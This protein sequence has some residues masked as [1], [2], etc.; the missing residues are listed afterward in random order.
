LNELV[1]HRGYTTLHLACFK[2]LDIM[3]EYI[4]ER[5]KSTL[6]PRDLKLWIDFKTDDDGFTALHFASFRGSFVLLELLL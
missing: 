3:A 5:A 2:N 1:D 4:I 6:S